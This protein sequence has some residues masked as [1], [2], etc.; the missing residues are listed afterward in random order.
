M[1]R[2]GF[3]RMSSQQTDL[4]HGHDIME[5]AGACR[6]AIIGAGY[7]AREHLKAFR[8]V[9][10][11]TLA[12][13]FSRTRDRAEK[14]AL[15]YGVPNVYGSVP[16]LYERTRAD[17]A[18]VTVSETSAKAISQACFEFPWTILMEKPPG[19]NLAESKE[20]YE[21]ATRLGR[22]VLVAL[23]RRFYSSTLAARKS[24]NELEGT[25]Y[26]HV[27]DQQDHSKDPGPHHSQI[28]RDN[29]MY[30]NSIHVIDLMRAFGRGDIIRVQ[31]I[32]RWNR[33]EPGVV[34]ATVEFQ[35]G[36]HGQYEGIWNG[37]GP[38]SVSVT[39]PQIR[40]EMRPLEQATYQL[41]G[42][43]TRETVDIHSW[44]NSFKPGFRIQAQM[45]VNSALGFSSESVTLAES[46]KSMELISQ[47]FEV[48]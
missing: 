5:N 19:I 18:V 11:V 20:I 7:T 9:P 45:A 8:D 2:F 26:I 23:N 44:D 43:R 13:I 17:L 37:P 3:T 27:Q 22:S 35:S 33:T 1:S 6:V 28:V 12:G 15:E 47:I 38:W 14:L 4:S 41:V 32:Y 34:L 29:W 39:A 25:R 48:G 10:G 21:S 42:T 30:A 40:W 36:D 24:L 16:E 31:S 46:V